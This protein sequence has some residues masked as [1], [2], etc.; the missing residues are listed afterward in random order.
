MICAVPPSATLLKDCP[1]FENLQKKLVSLLDKD[2]A[3][4]S[5]LEYPSQVDE[6][7]SQSM[8]TTVQTHLSDV[9]EKLLRDSILKESMQILLTSDNL[10][11]EAHHIID[12]INVKFRVML[13][14]T[15]LRPCMEIS[16]R[17]PETSSSSSSSVGQ[18]M[19]SIESSRPPFV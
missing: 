11:H 17:S 14:Q 13:A 1:H 9:N 16:A 2:G 18:R 10:P 5:E 12:S 7:D 6:I 8:L 15:C 19:N 4:S 3:I